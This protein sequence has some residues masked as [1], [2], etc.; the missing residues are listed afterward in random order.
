MLR[1]I[2]CGNQA[3]PAL[4]Y[5]HGLGQNYCFHCTQKLL[6]RAKRK[7]IVL[8]SELKPELRKKT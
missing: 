3:Y 8:E 1:C 5:L 4:R 6:M 2:R 7:P